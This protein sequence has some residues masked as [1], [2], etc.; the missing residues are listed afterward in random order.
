MENFEN[1]SRNVQLLTNFLLELG[2]YVNNNAAILSYT[3]QIISDRM[4]AD[5]QTSNFT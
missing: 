1:T 3:T 5:A 4:S 2:T